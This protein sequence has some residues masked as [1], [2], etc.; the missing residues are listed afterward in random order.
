[1][2][3][4]ARRTP[5][6]TDGALELLEKLARN[7]LGI[8]R[9]QYQMTVDNRTQNVFALQTIYS[10]QT[11]FWVAP[12]IVVAWKPTVAGLAQEEYTRFKKQI[13]EATENY[14]DAKTLAGLLQKGKDKHWLGVNWD[15]NGNLRTPQKVRVDQVKRLKGLRRIVEEK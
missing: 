12:S 9:E 7:K 2:L 11:E 6:E 5:S 3:M 8:A 1:M 15:K 14:D 4:L 10:S 13:A